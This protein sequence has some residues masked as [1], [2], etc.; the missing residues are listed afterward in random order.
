MLELSW[1]RVGAVLTR[2]GDIVDRLGLDNTSEIHE[3][4]EFPVV[5]PVFS[6]FQYSLAALDTCKCVFKA[7]WKHLGPSWRLLGAIVARLGASWSVLGAFFW[8]L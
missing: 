4:L 1:R 2:P 7:T 8:R 6:G 5:F 3:N